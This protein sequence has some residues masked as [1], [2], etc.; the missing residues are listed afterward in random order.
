M[1]AEETFKAW[2]LQEFTYLHDDL[3]EPMKTSWLE[4]WKQSREHT[5]EEAAKLVEVG[6]TFGAPSILDGDTL[7]SAAEAIR[8]LKS[9]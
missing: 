7:D 8:Q 4:A 3:I 5:L 6:I 2:R 9:K 1:N